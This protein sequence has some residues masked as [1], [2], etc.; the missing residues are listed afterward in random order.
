MVDHPYSSANTNFRSAPDMSWPNLCLVWSFWTLH[1]TLIFAFTQ[2]DLPVAF[3]NSVWFVAC[4]YAPVKAVVLLCESQDI[5]D[6]RWRGP[7]SPEY[8][9]VMTRRAMPT[10]TTSVISN[11]ILFSVAIACFIAGFQFLGGLFLFAAFMSM[12]LFAERQAYHSKL[13]Y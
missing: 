11:G 5:D 13:G 6:A 3:V 2:P 9:N 7:N 4:A 12:A 10:I 8:I 1:M